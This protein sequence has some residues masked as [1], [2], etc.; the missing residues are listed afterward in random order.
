MDTNTKQVKNLLNIDELDGVIGGADTGN[1]GN[2]VEKKKLYCDDPRCKQERIF[3]LG[4]GG[5]ATC[6]FC[7]TQIMY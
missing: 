3:Y 7:H 2:V 1:T 6:S 4:S 5:R